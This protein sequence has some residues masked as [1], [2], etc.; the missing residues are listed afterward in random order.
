MKCEA[1]QLLYNRGMMAMMGEG[2]RSE[3]VKLKCSKFKLEVRRLPG[4]GG[5]ALGC[6]QP[7]LEYTVA[8]AVLG[9]AV[10][11]DGEKCK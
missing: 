11:R 7:V 2:W 5:L 10:A 6:S 4:L 8:L 3:G 1:Y 9:S